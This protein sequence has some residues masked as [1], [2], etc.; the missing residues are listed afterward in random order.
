MKLLT[1]LGE[2]FITV[3]GKLIEYEYRKANLVQSCK[4]VNGRYIINIS[5]IPD[6]KPHRISCRITDYIPSK[7][8]GIESG[9]GLELK[10]FYNGNAKLS[11]GMVGD[12]VYIN[13]K[14]IWEYD[15]DNDYLDDGVE[16][17]ILDITE[18]QNFVFGVSW[19]NNCTEENDIQTWFGADPTIMN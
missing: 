6:G 10:S 12:S 9:E 11:I 17:V 5:F 3:D 1:P 13:G 14:R 19:L 16:Y 7:N 4:D 8:D 15:Y 2:L 18:T